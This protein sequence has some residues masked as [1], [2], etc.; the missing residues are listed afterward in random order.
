LSTG[1]QRY[2]WLMEKSVV[3]RGRSRPDGQLEIDYYHDPGP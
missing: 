2:G 1:D 3:G